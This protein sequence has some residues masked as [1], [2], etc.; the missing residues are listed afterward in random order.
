MK[1]FILHPHVGIGLIKLGARRSD[2]R[3]VM[4]GVVCALESERESVDY[5]CGSS[6]QVEYEEDGTASFIGLSSDR[7][8]ALLFE[9]IDL[10]DIEA[11]DV[12]ALLSSRDGS[13]AHEF[14][15]FEYVFPSQIIT[16]YDADPQYDRRR[17]ETRPV[18]GQIGCGD[19]RYLGACLR[20]GEGVLNP[21][22]KK[23]EK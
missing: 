22:R 2:V 18:W 4:T 23:D 10:F 14:S 21:V 17:N 16:L 20:I 8:I 6:I 13:G 15:E 19:H 12:F 5:F 11:K 1:H 7:D 9:G 3:A